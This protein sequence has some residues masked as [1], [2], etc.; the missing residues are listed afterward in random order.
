VDNLVRNGMFSAASELSYLAGWMAFDDA[1]HSIA[2]QY[3]SLAVALATEANDAPMEGHVLRAMAHQAIDLGGYRRG[4]DLAAA[5]IEGERYKLSSPRERALLGVV[6][7]RALGI[8]GQ[9]SAAARALIRAGEDLSA[10][11]TNYDGE[12]SRVFFFDEASLAHETARTLKDAGDLRGATREFHRSVR[13]RKAAHFTRTYAVTLGYLGA[14]QADMG[15]IDKACATWSSASDA[16]DGISSGRTR[17]VVTDMRSVLSG[18]SHRGSRV[19]QELDARARA[20]LASD[21]Q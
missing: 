7:A 13:T 10:A 8:T 19:A 2:Q 6:Y 12:P 17:Q 9:K 21:I 15:D 14:T 20:Y 4:W 5:S 11:K 1:E 3:F 16:M 18:V